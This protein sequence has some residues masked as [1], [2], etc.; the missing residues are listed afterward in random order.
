M[1]PVK[2]PSLMHFKTDPIVEGFCPVEHRRGA[3]SVHI[4]PAMKYHYH[5]HDFFLLLMTET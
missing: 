2:T 1:S 3:Y 4:N 5:Y